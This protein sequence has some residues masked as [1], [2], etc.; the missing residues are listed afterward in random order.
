MSTFTTDYDLFFWIMV[1]VCGLVG[2]GIACV[3]IAFAVRYHRRNDNELPTQIKGNVVAEAIWIT[4]PFILFLGMF[5][6][7]AK[8]YFDVELPPA[9]ALDIYVVAKQWMWKTQHPEG[10]REINELH[11]PIG[12]RVKLTMTS[13]DVI[14]SFFIP[15]F[16]IKQDVLPDR[17]TTLWFEAKTPGKYHLFCAE[18]CGT[19]HSGM[20]GWIY[21]ME[22]QEYQA[23]L[24]QGAPEGSLASTGEKLFHQFQ[25][26]TCHHFDGHGPCPDLRGLF[27]RTVN[28]ASG[29]SVTGPTTVVAD[30][31]FIREKVLNPRAKVVEGWKDNYMPSF[32]GQI[33]EDQMIDLIAYIK[34]MGPPPGGTLDTSSGAVPEREAAEPVI[35]GPGV[36]SIN[37]TVPGKR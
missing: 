11:V 9:D 18:Y 10:E 3:L 27:G 22:P 1:V 28:I 5:A 16:R 29:T 34:A 37:N 26:A 25:C 35:I 6:Y 24:E 12:R 13:Q 20:I 19:K 4:T 15:D 33:T 14:H 36:T 30:E 23:W 8:L 21:A 2:L 31:S 7:G 32:Q 17:Y